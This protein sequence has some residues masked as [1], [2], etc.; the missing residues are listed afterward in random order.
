MEAPSVIAFSQ[1]HQCVKCLFIRTPQ[2]KPARQ[3]CGGV[4]C[5]AGEGEHFHVQCQE[6]GFQFLMA[7]ADNPGPVA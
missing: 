2:M 3:F 5:E 1:Q 6:C 7:C 4:K